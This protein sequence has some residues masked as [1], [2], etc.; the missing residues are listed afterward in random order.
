MSVFGCF[1]LL[2]LLESAHLFLVKDDHLLG[3]R[4]SERY[5][6]INCTGRNRWLKSGMDIFKTYFLNHCLTLERSLPVQLKCTFFLLLLFHEW[7]G[8]E[9]P[10]SRRVHTTVFGE[11]AFGGGRCEADLDKFPHSL[12]FSH[13]KTKEQHETDITVHDASTLLEI[14]YKTGRKERKEE[15][16]TTV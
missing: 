8:C 5:L 4:Q 3:L 11:A 7:L 12:L 16:R 1:H 10:L 9:A 14:I 2:H 15:T 13:V 6:H